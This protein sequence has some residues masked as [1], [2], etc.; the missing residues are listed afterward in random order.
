MLT[1]SYCTRWAVLQLCVLR[2]RK[3]C[4]WLL[5][6]QLL[7]HAIATVL[8][9]V[10]AADTCEAAHTSKALQARHVTSVPTWCWRL[11]CSYVRVYTCMHVAL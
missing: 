6:Q 9:C 5:L 1:S 7:L 2:T 3:E 4:L 11:C 8:R 10:I